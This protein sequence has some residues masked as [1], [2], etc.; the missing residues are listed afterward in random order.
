MTVISICVFGSVAR[1]NSDC[2]SDKDVLLVSNSRFDAQETIKQWSSMGWSVSCYTPN[3]LLRMLKTGSLFL[4]H[5]KQDGVIVFDTDNW[6]HKLL[7][8]FRPKESYL[9]D[10]VLSES[11]ARAADRIP[12]NL[13]QSYMLC[14]VL[15]TYLRN[16][17]I[18]H[19]ACKG[20]FEFDY[21]RLLG[22]M[23]EIYGFDNSTFCLLE[24]L[25]QIKNQYRDRN[26]DNSEAKE[27]LAGAKIAISSI[28]GIQFSDL[29]AFSR[30]RQ[31]SLP[32]ATL[33]DAEARLLS[34][35]PIELLDL[36]QVEPEIASIWFNILDPRRYSWEVRKG[37][38]DSRLESLN[39][40]LGADR[41][42]ARPRRA[43]ARGFA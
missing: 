9:S 40:M 36:G 18:L 10:L 19:L 43:L 39:Q 24:K 23:A 6:L 32:Y 13:I 42:S 35:Y 2:F 1:G 27:T 3:R 41:A 29:D 31:L 5:L 28:F 30:V 38:N 15:Y 7:V 22:G 21:S 12:S 37:L 20:R 4:Q 8:S 16:A 26:F 33:R 11:L 34:S 14:D 17:C 25:R